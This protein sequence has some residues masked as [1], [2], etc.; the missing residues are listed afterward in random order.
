MFKV[1]SKVFI[2]AQAPNKEVT[3]HVDGDHHGLTMDLS[4]DR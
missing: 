2:D 1:I 3:V 4:D